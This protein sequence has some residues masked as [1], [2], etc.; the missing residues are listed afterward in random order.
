MRV[1][2]CAVAVGVM[3]LTGAGAA[4]GTPTSVG[5][6]VVFTQYKDNGAGTDS[7]ATLYVA[8][9]GSRS[10]RRLTE[11]CVDC[12]D[13]ARWSPDGKLLAYDGFGAD[14]EGGVF[15]MRA[16]GSGKRRLCGEPGQPDWR[17][18]GYEYPAWSP[19]GKTVAYGLSTSGTQGGGIRIERLDRTGFHTVPHTRSYSVGGVDWSPDGKRFAFE[20]S[21]GAV[22]V[23]G[24]DG[25]GLRRIAD[26]AV[27]PR[28]SPD[29][30]R[31]VFSSDNANSPG[32]FVATERGRVTEVLKAYLPSLGWWSN[33]QLFYAGLD[34][35]HVYD[36]ADRRDQRIAPLPDVCR[37][38]GLS[39][40]SFEVQPSPHG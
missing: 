9:L 11:P 15:L 6:L 12:S 38:R 10:A 24:A 39:C 28:W 14:F 34:G 33:N 35:L 2:L 3:L 19:D 1:G 18:D 13:Y 30:T 36:L 21:F 16:D 25:V 29:G 23:V 40:G 4:A 37:G 20:E 8:R 27:G 22:Y 31:L 7:D 32:V 26:H 5:R 17:C